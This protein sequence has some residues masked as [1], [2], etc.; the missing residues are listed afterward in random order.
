MQQRNRREGT[1]DETERLLRSA[2]ELAAPAI[3]WRHWLLF[4]IAIA[5]CVFA[6]STERIAQDPAYH[7]FADQVSLWRIPNALNV[8]SNVPFLLVGLFGL[9]RVAV[10]REHPQRRAF[11]CFSCGVALI[12][13]GSAY[14]HVRPSTDTLVWDRLPITVTFMAL[15]CAVIEDRVSPKYGRRMLVPAVFTGLVAVSFWYV[16]E[17]RGVGDL[18]AYAVVQFLPML[19]LPGV[20]LL[21]RVGGLRGGP[22]W[23]ALLL[24]AVAKLAEHFDS[25]ILV[26][27]GGLSGHSLKHL[28]A[29]LAVL[30]ALFSVASPEPSPRATLVA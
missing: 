22:L 10:W 21:F 20:L 12:A 8:L 19:L 23:G 18:R 24:Y 3:D 9:V 6:L 27:S 16:T 1:P 4:A 30:L 29:A 14:Y 7:T 25:Q 28:L 17:L 26:V 5:A 13:A 15:F 11:A 2:P